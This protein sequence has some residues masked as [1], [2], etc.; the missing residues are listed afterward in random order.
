MHNKELKS[1]SSALEKLP[2]IKLNNADYSEIPS[3]NANILGIGETIHGSKTLG[4][5]AFNMI[6]QRIKE[7]NCKLVLHE[8]PLESSL[9]VKR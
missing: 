4:N 6:K 9:F 1:E 2:I 5:V 3:M 7:N 8:F